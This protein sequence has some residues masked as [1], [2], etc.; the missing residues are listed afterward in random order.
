MNS[1]APLEEKVLSR[2][3]QIILSVVSIL[4]ATMAVAFEFPK[5]QRAL[6]PAFNVWNFVGLQQRWN[7]FAPGVPIMTAHLIGIVTLADG[8]KFVFEPPHPRNQPIL[9]RNL[10]NRYLKWEADWAL[11]YAYRPY[12]PS[13]CNH[14]LQ[15]FHFPDKKPKSCALLLEWTPIS[16]P[17]KKISPR[18]QAPERWYHTGLFKYEYPEEEKRVAGN[19]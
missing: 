6:A 12:L 7:L 15:E 14:I 8:S 13:L 2:K 1:P 18:D 11:A 3:T 17:Q 5:I 10:Y 9:T 16:N 4:Y 19:N